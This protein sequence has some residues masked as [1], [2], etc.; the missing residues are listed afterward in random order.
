MQVEHNK[1]TL[2]E[3][4]DAVMICSGVSREPNIPDIPNMNKYQGYI[5]HSALYK[6]HSKYSKSQSILVY[7]NSSSG[8]DV[9]CDLCKREKKV[10]EAEPAYHCCT[11]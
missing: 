8:L 7:G 1:R 10:G 4:F 5:D 3:E 9:A 2:V 11:D 6:N